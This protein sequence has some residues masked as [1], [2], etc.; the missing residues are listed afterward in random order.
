MFGIFTPVLFTGCGT[1]S[2][3]ENERTPYGGLVRDVDIAIHGTPYMESW[4]DQSFSTLDAPFSLVADTVTLPIT[5]FESVKQKKQRREDTVD[6][7]L[8]EAERWTRRDP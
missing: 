8:R 6:E 3:L 4:I 2:N 1:L 5:I 7:A